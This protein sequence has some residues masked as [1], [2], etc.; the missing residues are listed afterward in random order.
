MP[1]RRR[2]WGEHHVSVRLRTTPLKSGR[3]SSI[4]LDQIPHSHQG[5]QSAWASMELRHA[6]QAR[7]DVPMN[8]IETSFAYDETLHGRTI[9]L[10]RL[11]PGTRRDQL[12]CQLFKRRLCPPLHYK[13]LSYAWGDQS[14]TRNVYCD[15]RV[16]K[17]TSNLFSSL[18]QLGEKEI[19]E[20]LW[21]DAICM[22]Q[23]NLEER[24][25]R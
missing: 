9:R 14:D 23:L 6:L 13:A 7:K 18:W 19:Y 10:L 22:N 24:Q 4:C 15:N 25:T 3:E 20:Y 12:C 8:L 21:V 17:V 16:I 5:N 2:I 1:Q 11:L